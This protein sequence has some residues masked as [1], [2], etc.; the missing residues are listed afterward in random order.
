MSGMATEKGCSAERG[1]LPPRMRG[2]TRQ[3]RQPGTVPLWRTQDKDMSTGHRFLDGL[4]NRAGP[5]AQG[6]LALFFIRPSD[7]VPDVPQ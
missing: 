2:A 3:D 1:A 4:R 6:R 5:P 7:A